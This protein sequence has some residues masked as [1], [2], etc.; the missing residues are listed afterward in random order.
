MTVRRNLV[1]GLGKTGLSVVRWLVAS[2]EAVAVTDSRAEPPGLDALRALGSAVVTHLGGF[3]V[4][5]LSSADRIVLSP[6]VSRAEPLVRAALERGLPVV[7]DVELFARASAAPTVAITGTNGKSTV[8]TL[9]AEMAQAAGLRVRAGGNLGE[10]ALDLLAQP[11]PELYVLELSSYQLE[12]TDSLSLRAAVV[13]NV[14][15]DHMDRYASVAAYAAAK[16]RIYSNASVAVVNED[17]PVVREM[18]APGQRRIG[19]SIAG[20]ADFSIVAGASGPALAR[21]GVALLPLS[22]MRLPGRHNAANA[23]A[24]LAIGSE[25]GLAL[26]PMLA[27]LRSFGGLAHRTQVVAERGGVRFVDD[28][29]GTNVGATLAAVEGLAEP[30]V[31]IAGGDG[32]GQDFTPLAAA[33][34]GRVR[35]VVLIGRDRLRL[36]AAL[37]GACPCEFADDMDAAV[38]AA[39]RVARAG[40]LVLLSPA[41]A[42]LDMFRDYAARG[43]AFAAAA[44][45]LAA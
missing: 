16:A 33:F 15:P 36:A 26:E 29:K 45:R 12:S 27:T 37:E 13:L 8:T 4:G 6:G 9:V 34:R 14:T 44:R 28:S 7:G 19:F 10:P 11:A 42:S 41:C 17:D 40:D 22:E 35:H 38:V 23:L 25:L 21:G 43:D 20:V 30:L 31:V 2:G 3:D 39:A 1:V 24:A 32:K 18:P 5:A